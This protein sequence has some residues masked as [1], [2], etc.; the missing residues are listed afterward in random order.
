MA[1]F[2]GLTPE[3]FL[4]PV[5]REDVLTEVFAGVDTQIDARTTKPRATAINVTAPPYNADPTGLTDATQAIQ[6]AV[7]TAAAAGKGA[8]YIPA[9]AYRVSP[10]FIEMKPEVL[11]H[12]DGDSTVIF[13]DASVPA[14]VEKIGVFHIGTYNN[15]AQDPKMYRS[16]LRDLMIKTVDG[17]QAHQP[18]I[19]NVCGVILNTDLGSSTHDP[20]AVHSLR[21]L[22]IWDMHIGMAILGGDDQGMKISDI[23]IRGGNE[24]GLLVGKP[25]TH[26]EFVAGVPGGPGG[27]DNKFLNM[28]VSSSNK[29]GGVH[30]GIEVHTS[31]CK[32]V[33]ST[34][35]YNRRF[36]SFAGA[37]GV[38]R[39]TYYDGAGWYIK[40]TKNVFIGCTAQEN[41]GHGFITQY[42]GCQFIGCIAESNSWY[43]SVKGTALVNEAS[44]FFVC[45]G[46]SD[47]QIIS[48]RS[49]N[50]RGADKGQAY[51]YVLENYA[52]NQWVQGTADQNFAG[53]VKFGSDKT[54]LT[55]D[56][57]VRVGTTLFN[58][59]EGALSDL[60]NEQVK[61]LAT[62]VALGL[63]IE[64]Q[65]GPTELLGQYTVAGNTTGI[66]LDTSMVPF[67]GW[68]IAA[69][70]HTG[71]TS[72]TVPTGWTSLAAATE[73]TGR[74]TILARRKGSSSEKSVTLT[75][76]ATIPHGAVVLYGKGGATVDKWELGTRWKRSAATPTTNTAPAVPSTEP[77][78]L[79]FSA[80]RTTTAEGTEPT[81]TNATKLAYAGQGVNIETMWVGQVTDPSQDVVVT[82]P[83]PQDLNGQAM[84]IVIP[85]T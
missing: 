15:R 49:N 80:E 84:Q 33:N 67:G 73:G 24:M 26:P 75:S 10:P 23:R 20:D 16:S 48:A 59:A 31:N 58:W 37:Q 64:S 72:I 45:N 38:D 29:L 5:A 57:V 42:P 8:V 36:G 52:K 71:G 7:N 21:G 70:S 66:T 22:T 79:A 32:F 55:K 50:A 78:V 1:R 68:V 35:W 18:A 25:A 39:A 69:V 14:P 30:A 34:S 76:T 74:M 53:D 65:A 28:D 81:A 60:A 6:N 44:G 47:T 63:I 2:M 56:V 4:P 13:V 11:I 62:E 40:G 17:S 83:N 3:G 51:G 27:A 61:A 41:G 43:D 9:G 12:G 82:Y 77:F 54:T 85:G 46:A 19:E